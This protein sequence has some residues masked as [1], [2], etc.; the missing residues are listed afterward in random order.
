M[1]TEC[2]KIVLQ[3]YVKGKPHGKNH[4]KYIISRED[5]HNAIDKLVTIGFI[6]KTDEK[7]I[8]QIGSPVDIVKA[9]NAIIK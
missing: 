6:I 4:P 3:W 9:R 8:F 1:L 5:F 7:G 2:E